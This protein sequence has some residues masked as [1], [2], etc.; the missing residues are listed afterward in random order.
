[1]T[2]QK[3]FDP[4]ELLAK[5]ELAHAAIRPI[6]S[7]DLEHAIANHELAVYYQPIIRRFADNTWDISAVEALVRWNHLSVACS[8]PIRS[9]Q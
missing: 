4:E 8:H 9:W 2:L 7:A 5:L 1:M 6:T 3:P